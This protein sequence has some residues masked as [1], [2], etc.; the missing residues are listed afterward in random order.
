MYSEKIIIQNLELFA[1]RE[2]WMPVYHSIDEIEQVLRMAKRVDVIDT[3]K[4]DVLD[5]E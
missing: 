2:K 3:I 4:P 1:A 5:V